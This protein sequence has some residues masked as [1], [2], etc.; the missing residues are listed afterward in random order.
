MLE[1]NKIENIVE[2]LKFYGYTM[3]FEFSESKLYIPLKELHLSPSDLFFVDAG[4]KDLSTNI[5]VFAIN[6]PLYDSKGYLLLS[7]DDYNKLMNEGYSAKFD[8]EIIEFSNEVPVV[9]IKRQYNMRKVTREE[10][11]ETRY[12]LREGF[13]DFPPCPYGHTFKALGYDKKENEYV[14]LASSILKNEKVNTI[15]Y[16]H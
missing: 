10:Y 11:D 16:T 8:L 1:E 7:Q 9:E 6:S 12:E 3:I 15:K 13:P 2:D 4:Y 5:L 14:R